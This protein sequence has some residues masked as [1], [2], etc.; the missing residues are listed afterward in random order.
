LLFQLPEFRAHIWISGYPSKPENFDEVTHA[1]NQ[2]FPN[3]HFQL[4][5]LNKVPGS[6]YLFLATMNAM[7]SFS[8]KPISKSLG[9][10]ILLYIAASRQI[11]EAIRLVGVAPNTE[12]IAVILV[13]ITEEDLRGA[14]DLL[15]R[16]IGQECNDELIDSW[17][18]ERIRNVRAVFQIGPK[19]L[20]STLRKN[21]TEAQAV[22]RL[23]IERSALLTIRK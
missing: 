18:K 22:E 7:K 6:R 23:A 8:S 12:K 19:E 3:A 20:K 16:T 5:D 11:I 15:S 2:K 9:M 21:E 4:V 13:G 1:I 10:E 14:V 17:S